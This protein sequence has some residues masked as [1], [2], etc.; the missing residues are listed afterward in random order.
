[1]TAETTTPEVR[2]IPADMLLGGP[3]PARRFAGASLSPALAVVLVADVAPGT[4][5][6]AI[7][8]AVGGTF[9]ALEVRG[10]DAGGAVVMSERVLPLP[11]DGPLRLYLGGR[12]V[13]DTSTEDLGSPTEHLAS[14]AR[15]VGGLRAGEVVLL[16]PAASHRARPGTGEVWGPLSSTLTTTLTEE[17][18]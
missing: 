11:C 15:Q 10:G 18:S 16:A 13:V 2:R 8:L 7:H 9:L 12:L 3:L 14:L 4:P 1:V 5:S 6:E 17:E